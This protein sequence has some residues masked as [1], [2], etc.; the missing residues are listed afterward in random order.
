MLPIAFDQDGWLSRGLRLLSA[1]RP[2]CD[3]HRSPS[4]VTL[5]RGCRNGAAEPRLRERRDSAWG[6]RGGRPP[7][8]RSSISPGYG[9]RRRPP[10]NG[11]M[12]HAGYAY[13]GAGQPPGRGRVDGLQPQSGHFTRVLPQDHHDT[14]LRRQAPDHCRGSQGRRDGLLRGDHRHGR[15]GR[16]PGWTVATACFA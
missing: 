13:R 5:G 7:R 12:L 16:R 1:E 11:S 8:A 2:L 3:R 4:L 6:R 10:G 9:P 15:R 14:N